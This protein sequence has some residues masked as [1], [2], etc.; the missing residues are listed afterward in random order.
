[1]KRALMFWTT[2]AA[3]AL[4]LVG[5]PSLAAAQTKA[6]GWQA[7]AALSGDS[8]AR[9]ACFDQWSASQTREQSSNP[10][11]PGALA[12]DHIT[13]TPPLASAALSVAAPPPAGLVPVNINVS[14]ALPRDCR[15][16]QYSPLS[17]F[18]EL[19]EGTDCGRFTIRGYH[20]LSLS[21]I[22]SDGVNTQPSS[23]AA[24]RT[25]TA[26]TAYIQSETRIQLSVR[27]KIAQGFLPTRDPLARDSLWFGYTQQSYWQ[28][29]SGDI[30]RPFRTTDHEPEIT[31]VYPVDSGLSPGWHIRMLGASLVHQSNGQTDPLSRSWNRT[32]LMAGFEHNNNQRVTAKVWQRLPEKALEDDNPEI[33]DTIGRAEV[34][35]FW[36]INPANT[37]GMT[38]R[39]SL[40]NNPNGSIRLE[41][42][43]AIGETKEG[44]NKSGLRFHAQLFSGFGDSLA[45]YNRRRTVLSLGLSLVDW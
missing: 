16:Q 45:D 6:D 3:Y 41:W 5:A 34:A 15:H 31:Y 4:C 10:K 35:G 36:D 40:T 12:S 20:P 28:L 18:W 19:E 30:S 25:A 2:R 23:S 44:I 24:A 38:W 33:A 11:T 37:V 8:A 1:M 7:C 22:G 43:K 42:L 13:T 9:L 17:R 21:W 14:S 32:I 29:F 27:T 26:A 39:H